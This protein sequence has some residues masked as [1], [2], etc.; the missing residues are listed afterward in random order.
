MAVC[1]MLAGMPLTSKWIDRFP[2]DWLPLIY[3]GNARLRLDGK[4]FDAVR[5]F[6]RVLELKPDNPESHLALAIVLTNNGD[7]RK[8]IPHFQA[9]LSRQPEDNRVL[10]GLA[11][12]L[13]S[14]GKSEEARAVLDRLFATGKGDPAGFLL[15]AKIELAEGSPQLA[16]IWLK[17]AE[18]LAP[19]E[20]DV[21]NALLLACGQLGRSSEAD[22][23]RR[24][25]DE[26]HTRDA[27]LDRLSSALKNRPDDADLRF[28]VGMACLKLG[29]EAEAAHW[30][31]GILWKEPGHLPTLNALAE[32]YE[33]KGDQKKADHYR[34]K[35]N[36]SR[37]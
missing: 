4:P 2:D 36:K 31:Q 10:F 30:F 25:L 21:V 11:N 23:Y 5:D 37:S 22:K 15:R 33:S 9:C 13:H 8:A 14:L 29:R 17:K 35:G 6:Q 1:L 16:L 28:K 12:C 19:K 20:A 26:I 32:Y 34:R 27:E 7:F 24:L 3:R 18:D